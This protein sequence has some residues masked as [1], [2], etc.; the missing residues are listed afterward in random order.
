VGQAGF[1]QAVHSYEPVVCFQSFGD[2]DVDILLK[3]RALTW[4]D[5]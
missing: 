4:R 2:S 3:L 5:S 1:K